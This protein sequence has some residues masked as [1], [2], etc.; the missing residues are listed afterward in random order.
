MSQTGGLLLRPRG[1]DDWERFKDIISKYYKHNSL[2]SLMKYMK[3]A[4]R[5]HATY[6][7][8]KVSHTCR[9]LLTLQ[10][11]PINSRNSSK[12]GRLKKMLLLR[13]WSQSAVSGNVDRMKA[14]TPSLVSGNTISQNGRS[15]AS[16]NGRARLP[17]AQRRLVLILKVGLSLLHSNG[18]I[19]TVS[20]LCS[21]RPFPDP[22]LD[23]RGTDHAYLSSG[24]CSWSGNSRG[25]R[26]STC[27]QH[28]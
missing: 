8:G 21:I 7:P 13:R 17:F 4:H 18:L 10:Q 6:V 20:F 26:A 25:A 3:E 2:P 15:S 11:D 5:F 16:R 9:K 14:K 28:F 24:G 22:L 19:L 23:S 1:S 12:S 27:T